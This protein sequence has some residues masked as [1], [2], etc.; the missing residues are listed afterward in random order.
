MNMNLTEIKKKLKGKA[1]IGG[2]PTSEESKVYA[3]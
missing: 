3:L 1:I 2:I